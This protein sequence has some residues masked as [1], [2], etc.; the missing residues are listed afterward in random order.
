MSLVC[1]RAG[2]HGPHD[3]QAR[4]CSICGK[5]LEAVRVARRYR[6]PSVQPPMCG[7]EGVRD[8]ADGE[9]AVCPMCGLRLEPLVLPAVVNCVNEGRPLAS[10]IES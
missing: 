9:E 6:C 2:A 4:F 3:D 5:E 7:W 10:R 1:P 8:L